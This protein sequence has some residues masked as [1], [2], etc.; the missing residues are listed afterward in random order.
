LS[1]EIKE[2]QELLDREKLIED[3]V[4]KAKETARGILEAAH[5]E[6][7]SIISA[8]EMDPEWEKLEGAKTDDI[9]RKKHELEE[10]YTR[11]IAALGKTALENLDTAINRIIDETLRVKK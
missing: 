5:K 4:K 1:A 11:N 10:Q 2:L 8:I 7:D 3:Q 6:A 9:L